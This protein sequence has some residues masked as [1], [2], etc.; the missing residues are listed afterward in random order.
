MRENEWRRSRLID[1]VRDRG[2]AAR[3][4]PMPDRDIGESTA[5][6]ILIVSATIAIVVSALAT[7]L[8]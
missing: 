6:A 7:T 5:L 2:R 8:L 1:E 3:V 4:V